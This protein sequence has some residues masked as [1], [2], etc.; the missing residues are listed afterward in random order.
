[1]KTFEQLKRSV[2]YFFLR[3][4]MLSVLV[5]LGR[6]VDCPITNVTVHLEFRGATE[7]SVNRQITAMP[8]QRSNSL[9]MMCQPLGANGIRRRR[10]QRALT[11]QSILLQSR[12]WLRRNR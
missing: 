4:A 10:S 1:M 3:M 12:N 5:I 9:L 11:P 2:R 7:P 8:N 6:H